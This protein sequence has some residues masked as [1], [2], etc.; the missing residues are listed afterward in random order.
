MMKKTK[1]ESKIKKRKHKE[2]A[3]KGDI[4]F[5]ISIIVGIFFIALIFYIFYIRGMSY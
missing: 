1:E 5:R 2:K 3:T 4:I